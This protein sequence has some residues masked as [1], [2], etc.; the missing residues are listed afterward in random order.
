M[1]ANGKTVF[2]ADDITASL[3]IACGDGD[4]GEVLLRKGKRKN[5]GTG[6]V[7]ELCKVFKYQSAVSLSASA[8]SAA[9]PLL[10]P[11]LLRVEL[12]TEEGLGRR[13]CEELSRSESSSH[14]IM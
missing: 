6:E 12:G 3:T 4:G 9:S 13:K 1:I 14:G 7:G 5:S 8:V 10:L 11:W 2:G